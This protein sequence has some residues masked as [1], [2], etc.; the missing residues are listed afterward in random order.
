ILS[1]PGLHAPELLAYGCKVSRRARP[2]QHGDVT[3][4]QIPDGHGHREL[5]HEGEN[6]DAWLM[7]GRLEDLP[8]VVSAEQQ[9]P[10]QNELRICRAL[11]LAVDRPAQCLDAAGDAGAGDGQHVPAGHACDY[12][13][14]YGA[15]SLRPHVID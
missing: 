2:A 7:S 4:V 3:S 5:V 13:T 9:G 11:P 8:C 10:G 6:T 12:V 15:G 14:G 1:L